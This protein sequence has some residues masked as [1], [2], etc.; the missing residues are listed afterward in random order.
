[1]DQNQIPVGIYI[2]LIGEVIILL[3]VAKINRDLEEQIRDK[4]RRKRTPKKELYAI[5]NARK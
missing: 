4:E 1:M 2:F 5:K 3:I